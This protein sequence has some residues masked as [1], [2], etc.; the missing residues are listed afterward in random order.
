MSKILASNFELDLSPFGISETINN[1]IFADTFFTKYTLPF[2]IDITKDIDVAFDF[3]S[4]VTAVSKSKI[5]CKFVEH[6]EIHD[7]I[8]SVT[9]VEQKLSCEI[10]YGFEEYPSFKKKLSELSLEHFDLAPGV[11]IYEHAETIIPL[12]WPTTNYNFPQVHTDKYDPSESLYNGFEKVINN[13][14]LGAF[15]INEYDDVEEINFN[16]NIMQPLVA[17]LHILQRGFIDGGYE[18]DGDILNDERLQKALIYADVDYFHKMEA[19]SEYI[20][21]MN[22]PADGTELAPYYFQWQKTLTITL[23]EKTLYKFIG[24]I[25]IARSADPEQYVRVYV[26]E[27]LVYNNTIT[28]GTPVFANVP[29][30]FNAILN[31]GVNT[32]VYDSKQRMEFYA[33]RIISDLFV[34]PIALLDSFDVPYSTIVNEPN[35]DLRRAVPDMTFQDYVK[36]FKNY[37]NYDI[38]GI[39]GN[40]LFMNKVQNNLD[41]NDVVDLSYSQIQY[42][43][44]KPNE[45]KTFLLKFQDIDST[46]YSYKQVLH[47]SDG[48]ITEN[49]VFDEE[50][51]STIEIN[52]LPLPLTT[53][54]AVT[55]AHAFENNQSKVYLV[56]YDGIFNGNNLARANDN[57]LLP[58][59]YLEYWIRWLQFR[60]GSTE[61][62]WLFIVN[63]IQMRDIK[64]KSK[65]F[66]YQRLHLIKSIQKNEVRPNI[67]EVELITETLI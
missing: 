36:F 62:D 9:Q 46:T 38:N 55:T 16:R 47:K 10:Q 49:I 14:K 51:N 57:Y 33:N 27:V 41:Q 61:F 44:R 15:L 4:V 20:F 11:T 1:T 56:H 43:V 65:I 12:G 40:K 67:F 34:N 23:T 2:E 28:P 5:E 32:I 53:R 24:E 64:I 54:N 42:P 52:G 22:D 35:V 8:L 31:V 3:I 25:G 45:Q 39:V 48:Y 60:T 59:V 50:T 37:L 63:E 21:V 19:P 29:V 26:N 13:R 58:E 17:P 30:D 7:A 6:D 66:A 18:L